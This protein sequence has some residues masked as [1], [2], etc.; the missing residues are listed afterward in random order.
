MQQKHESEKLS[1]H[2]FKQISFERKTE[3]N[4]RSIKKEGE[5]GGRRTKHEDEAYQP[6]RWRT[7]VTITILMINQNVGGRRSRTMG[8]KGS[9]NS[10]VGSESERFD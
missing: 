7:N 5:R 3:T 9:R 8:E 10:E 6:E 2:I 4:E 1:Q